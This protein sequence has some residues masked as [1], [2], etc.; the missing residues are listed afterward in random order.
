VKLLTEEFHPGARSP[1]PPWEILDENRWL[2]ARHGLDAELVDHESAD[3]TPVRDLTA[4]LLERLAPHATELGCLQEL[5]GI[6]D[7]LRSGNGAAR[8]QM[9]YEA[10]HDLRELMAEIVARTA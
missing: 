5:D 1:D 10:N 4:S 7:L 3:R 9:V 2:A 8:Q 6:N